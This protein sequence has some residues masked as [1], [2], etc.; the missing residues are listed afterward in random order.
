RPRR[1]HGRRG[2]P[3]AHADRH[4]ADARAHVRGMGLPARRGAGVNELFKAILLVVVGLS[5]DPE[6]AELFKKWGTTMATAA[7]NVG[8]PPDRIIQL[9]EQSTKVDVEAAFASVAKKTGTDDVVFVVL[10]GHGSFDGKVAKLN[11]K[12]P[13]MSAPDFN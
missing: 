11:L 1:D 10:I 13:D 4:G 8:V 12:G 7:K 6:H 5:G 3:L 9:G 2:G